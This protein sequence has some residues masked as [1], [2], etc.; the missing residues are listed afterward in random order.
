MFRYNDEN[1][2]VSTAHVKDSKSP[3][4]TVVCRNRRAPVVVEEYK[5]IEEAIL[6]HMQW[7]KMYKDR[8]LPRNL[9]DVGTNPISENSRQNAAGWVVDIDESVAT[10]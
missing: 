8:T 7:L 9:V 3:F 5:S 4:E 2:F 6:G 10:N 1:G